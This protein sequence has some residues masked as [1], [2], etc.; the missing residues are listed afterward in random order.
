MLVRVMVVDA[1]SSQ[2]VLEPSQ[3]GDSPVTVSDVGLAEIVKSFWPVTGLTLTSRDAVCDSVGDEESV[4]VNFMVKDPAVENVW[5]GLATVLVP[6]SPNSHAYMK[7]AVPPLTIEVKLTDWPTVGE[8]GEKVK[9]TANGGLTEVMVMLTVVAVVVAPRGVPVTSTITLPTVVPESTVIVS[10]LEP[11]G[12]TVDGLNEVHVTPEGRG[13]RQDNATGCAVPAI[14]VALIVTV[15][16]LPAV[17]LI[18][19]LLVKE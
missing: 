14:N 5:L 12:V 7:G 2:R 10:I 3:R 6:P 9:S 4:T 11:V 19:P 18:G 8:E 1:S 13:V 15:P 16:E 17:I